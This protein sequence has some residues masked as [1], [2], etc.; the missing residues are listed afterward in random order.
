M[1]LFT[2]NELFDNYQLCSLPGFTSPQYIVSASVNTDPYKC[3]GT[4]N[5]YIPLL[6]ITCCCYHCADVTPTIYFSFYMN[7]LCL[8]IINLHHDV[9]RFQLE[10][11]PNTVARVYPYYTCCVSDIFCIYLVLPR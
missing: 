2:I 10:L 6:I 11:T 1:I 4:C 3:V 7:I 5:A 9:V 8:W